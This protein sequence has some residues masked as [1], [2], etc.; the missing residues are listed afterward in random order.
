MAKWS[1][2][3][4]HAVVWTNDTGFGY[5]LRLARFPSENYQQLIAAEAW[6]FVYAY[7]VGRQLPRSSIPNFNTAAI[8]VADV[9]K[10]ESR[11]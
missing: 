8:E 1:K 4:T 3:V 9:D 10:T 6:D 11:R 5:G 7:D 2:A